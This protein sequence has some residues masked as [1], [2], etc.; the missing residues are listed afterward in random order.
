M[1]LRMELTDLIG[2]SVGSWRVLRPLGEGAFGAVFEAE[3]TGIPGKYG[4]VKVLRPELSVQSGIKQRFLNEASAASRAEHENIVQIY[5]GGITPDG[6]CY[7][8]MELLKGQTLTGLIRGGRLSEARAVNVGVQLAGALAAAHALGVVH[9][10]LKPDNVF[11]VPRSQN[12]EFVK[13]LDFG[14]AKLRGEQPQNDKLT[15]TGMIIGTSPYMSPEQW[16]AQ[17]D[18]DGR[19]D[20]YALGVILFECLAGRRPFSATNPIEWAMV[21]LERPPPDLEGYGISPA[22]SRAVS[23]MLAKRRED[24]PQSMQDV[25]RDLRAAESPGARLAA[26]VPTRISAPSF[27]PQPTPYP[28]AQPTP[29]P[30]YLQPGGYPQGYP[31][32]YAQ[33]GWTP[34]QAMMMGP[35]QP[36]LFNRQRLAKIGQFVLGAVIFGAYAIYNWDSLIAMFKQA[37]TLKMP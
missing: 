29:A 16:M 21:H 37:F 8:V 22:L 18:I 33:P 25:I 15:S 11:I 20:I 36:S 34:Q 30:A 17:P 24:R 7:S 26:E 2:R 10:D 1:L 19:S 32:G 14:V 4:A 9:R 35:P 28:A 3:H 23:R 13:V 27:A 31:Q 12:P 6:T 5:D